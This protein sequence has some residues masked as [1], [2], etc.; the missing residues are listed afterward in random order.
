MTNKVSLKR[1][2]KPLD[3]YSAMTIKVSVGYNI[4]KFNN[5]LEKVKWDEVFK[6]ELGSLS[7]PADY[8]HQFVFLEGELFMNLNFTKEGGQHEL[9]LT[10]KII[11]LLTTINKF[12]PEIEDGDLL[13]ASEEASIN[14]IRIK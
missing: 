14:L 2:H 13:L 10:P 3:G 4:S 9:K 7:S 11:A 12:S 8:I 1:H 6:I 5:R